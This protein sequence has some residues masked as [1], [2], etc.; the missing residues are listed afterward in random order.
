MSAEEPAALERRRLRKAAG[1]L[2]AGRDQELSGSSPSRCLS[3]RAPV[4]PGR[5]TKFRT[6]PFGSMLQS[7]A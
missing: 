1:R 5:A 7:R 6:C 3:A 2:M 4:R